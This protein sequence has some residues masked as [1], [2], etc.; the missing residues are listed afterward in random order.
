VVRLVNIFDEAERLY[1]V[2]EHVAGGDLLKRLLQLPE[3][4]LDEPISRVVMRCLLSGAQYLHDVGVAHRDLKP[5]NVLVE[6]ATADATCNGTPRISSVK[7]T[8]FGLSAINAKQM[9]E[10]LGTMAYAAPEILQGRPYDR[11]VDIWSLGVMAFVVLAGLLP[12]VGDCDRTVAK[13]VVQGQYSFD[14]TRWA[15]VSL[16]ARDF[17][18]SLLRHKP[19]DRPSAGAALLHRW[20]Q[21][22]T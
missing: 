17:I 1:L 5:D 4:R 22:M 3:Q 14:S 18:K 10:P 8:D 16:A 6:D 21:D 13:A 12:F 15:S 2:M 19:S 7:I 9:Q 11:A 20:F